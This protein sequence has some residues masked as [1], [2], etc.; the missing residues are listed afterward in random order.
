MLSRVWVR[1]NCVFVSAFASNILSLLCMQAPPSQTII[2]PEGAYEVD[3]A[4]QVR[5]T[6][7]NEGGGLPMIQLEVDVN[8]EKSTCTGYYGI[9]PRDAL[10]F[11]NFGGGKE[12]D[13]FMSV[14][15]ILCD[16]KVKKKL[17]KCILASK[18]DRP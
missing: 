11:D 9:Q 4:A 17:K 10:T 2:I 12:I 15:H 16:F 8:G 14:L 6:V 1:F 5:N 18:R 7:A 13:V 3:F